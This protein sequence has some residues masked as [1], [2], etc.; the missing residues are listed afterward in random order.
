MSTHVD[1]PTEEKSRRSFF[2][3]VNFSKCSEVH[4]GGGETPATKTRKQRK[5]EKEARPPPCPR[6][7]SSTSKYLRRNLVTPAASGKARKIHLKPGCNDDAAGGDGAEN[8]LP[9]VRRPFDRLKYDGE[10]PPAVDARSL[11]KNG[12]ARFAA[13]LVC[14]PETAKIRLAENF[15]APALLPLRN[16]TEPSVPALRGARLMFRSPFLRLFPSGLGRYSVF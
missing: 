10:P 4:G 9:V 2:R 5:R 12:R 8:S 11:V 15:V 3:L 7:S 1:P 13:A 16:K 14:D 6:P